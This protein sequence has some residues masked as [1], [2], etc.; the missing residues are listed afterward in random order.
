MGRMLL[1]F[2]LVVFAVISAEDNPIAI[3]F[4]TAGDIARIHHELRGLHNRLVS[5]IAVIGGDDQAV[6]LAD[7]CRRQ[8][9]R[10][11]SRVI[12][13][14]HPEMPCLLKI[15][16]RQT[17]RHPPRCPRFAIQK[18]Q[19]DNGSS[20]GPQ[21]TWHLSDLRISHRHIPPGCP[22]VNGKVE[23][24]HKTDSQEGISNIKGILLES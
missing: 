9:R 14:A 20:F 4:D 23:R 6:V 18:I 16:K 11:H 12:V 7:I 21:F 22:E 8:L 13:M 10:A 2:A 5:I 24:S 17:Q 1:I 3:A 19:T 15:P